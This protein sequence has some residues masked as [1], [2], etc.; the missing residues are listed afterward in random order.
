MSG[1]DR[2]F[3]LPQIKR[4]LEELSDGVS[5]YVPI[6]ENESRKHAHCLLVTKLRKLVN[7][8]DSQQY[9]SN[10]FDPREYHGDTWLAV[11]ESIDSYKAEYCKEFERV[12]TTVYN[13]KLSGEWGDFEEA[14]RESM[15][16]AS[17]NLVT[18]YTVLSREIQ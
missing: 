4:V 10:Y 7:I 12:M 5:R 14:C 11:K 16:A 15:R 2:G 6:P 3:N 9:R 1:G 18:I 13:E 17:R 8:V